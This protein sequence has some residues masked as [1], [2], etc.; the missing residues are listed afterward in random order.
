MLFFVKHN[1]LI[2]LFLRLLKICILAL[3]SHLTKQSYFFLLNLTQNIFIFYFSM[4]HMKLLLALLVNLLFKQNQVQLY[5]HC[6]LVLFICLYL[7]LHMNLLMFLFL[8][9]NLYVLLYLRALF[10]PCHLYYP[11]SL[12]HF[13]FLVLNLLSLLMYLIL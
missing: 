12:S 10:Y 13:V 1:F 11:L 5:L 4:N 8:S 7:C 6:P 9:V 2:A 3:L